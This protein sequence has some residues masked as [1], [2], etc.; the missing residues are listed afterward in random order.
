MKRDI[1]CPADECPLIAVM[2]LHQISV[3]YGSI[4]VCSKIC[5]SLLSPKSV[6]II[7]I[8]WGA[9]AV[10]GVR[11][12]LST[13]HI[14]KQIPPAYFVKAPDNNFSDYRKKL[15]PDRIRTG[16]FSSELYTE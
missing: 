15:Q 5:G 14:K 11:A 10:Q 3:K 7:Y 8:S 4:A 12:L 6:L 13:A 2:F 9:A 1:L 16:C